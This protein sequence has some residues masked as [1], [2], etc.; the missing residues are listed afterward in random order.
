MLGLEKNTMIEKFCVFS[1][2]VELLRKNVK[3]LV[4]NTAE[5]KLSP[6]VI[7]PS[8]TWH[9]DDTSFVEKL[10]YQWFL[11]SN[12]KAKASGVVLFWPKNSITSERLKKYFSFFI[13]V[14]DFFLPSSRKFSEI[15]IYNSPSKIW[16]N[17]LQDFE[18]LLKANQVLHPCVVVGDMNID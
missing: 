4:E 12:H 7:A 15:V 8:K 14:V 9:S 1:Q 13:L 16:E 5:N 3:L 6:S 11:A 2:N 10:G 18:K 17:F